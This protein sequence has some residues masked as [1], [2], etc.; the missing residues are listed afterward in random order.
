MNKKVV[1]PMTLA[2]NRNCAANQ[3]VS[4][5]VKFFKEDPKDKMPINGSDSDGDS[6]DDDDDNDDDNGD[7]PDTS[8]NPQWNSTFNENNPDLNL[9]DS[10]VTGNNSS[11]QTRASDALGTFERMDDSG[12]VQFRNDTD[13]VIL[14]FQAQRQRERNQSTAF[15]TSGGMNDN[16]QA[17]SSRTRQQS[18]N[19]PYVPPRG[20][21]FGSSESQEE[22]VEMAESNK[23]KSKSN[24]VTKYQFGIFDGCM[25]YSCSIGST[26]EKEKEQVKNFAATL[27]RLE[28]EMKAVGEANGNSFVRSLEE[29][30]RDIQNQTVIYFNLLMNMK[31]A[32]MVEKLTMCRPK[33]EAMVRKVNPNDDVEMAD[34]DDRPQSRRKSEYQSIILIIDC[35]T[36]LSSNCASQ[37][38]IF[39]VYI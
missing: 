14:N 3:P 8:F 12:E 26:N 4:P 15:G 32:A 19:S 21:Q 18:K 27:A 5:F 1:M 36:F 37:P 2:D 33:L 20:F 11:N 16:P 24:F 35:A 25:I 9:S 22:D 17:A 7:N 34:A 23:R 30:S 6:S 28:A 39:L 38:V 31:D 29:I 13:E 10:T